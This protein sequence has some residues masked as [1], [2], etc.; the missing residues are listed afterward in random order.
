MPKQPRR[1]D[2]SDL[3]KDEVDLMG[4]LLQGMRRKN[5]KAAV[6]LVNRGWAAWREPGGEDLDL[7]PL[8]VEEARKLWPGLDEDPTVEGAAVLLSDGRASIPGRQLQLAVPPLVGDPDG[9]LKALAK[10]VGEGLGAQELAEAVLHHYPEGRGLATAPTAALVAIGVPDETSTRIHDAFV[11]ARSCRRRT[12]R[13][14]KGIHEASDMAEAVFES[15]GVADLEVEHL[16]VGAVDSGGSL[17][18]VA[19]VAKGSLSQVAVSMRDVF[20]P[21]CRARAAACFVAHNHPSCDLSFSNDDLRL[22]QRI[23]ACATRMEIAVLDH[24]ILA[25]NGSYSSLREQGGFQ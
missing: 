24:V 5:L 2:E 16:W 4:R 17:I 1:I 10:V 12:E 22:T 23:V 21:L 11:L 6:R 7:T 19:E 15:F 18:D 25:P 14:G 8:G 13:W 20:T 9:L 3:L